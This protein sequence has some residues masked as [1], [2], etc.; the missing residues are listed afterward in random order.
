MSKTRPCFKCGRNRAERFFTSA[1]GRTCVSCRRATARRVSRSTRLRKTY[2]LDPADYETILAYQ[3][4]K[5]A[6]CLRVPR[7]NMDVD[8]DHK[9]GLI[10]GLLCKLC[11][12]RLLPSARDDIQTLQR[13]IT[14]LDLAPALM[15]LARCVFVD[16]GS[17]VT[18]I[19]EMT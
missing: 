17:D 19:E 8:H 4:G 5:C 6:I 2:G 16:Q 1:R 14:Y 11:N 3:N 12:R 13:A 9:T 10:R 15:A 18:P 7:Y